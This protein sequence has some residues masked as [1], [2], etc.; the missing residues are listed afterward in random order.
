[1]FIFYRIHIQS[2]ALI[3]MRPRAFIAEQLQLLTVSHAESLI[4]TF[5]S[6][7]SICFKKGGLQT[8]VS[9]FQDYGCPSSNVL[10]DLNGR[11]RVFFDVFLI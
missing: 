11:Q 3:H 2:R 5:L 4:N 10:V 7:I 9:G 8:F 6:E 1:M